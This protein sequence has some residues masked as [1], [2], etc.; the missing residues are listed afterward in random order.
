M[1]RSLSINY[2][3]TH[4]FHVVTPPWQ[5]TWRSCVTRNDL[6]ALLCMSESE[7][8]SSSIKL[9]VNKPSKTLPKQVAFQT[10]FYLQTTFFHVD[11]DSKSISIILKSYLVE[12]GL[13]LLYIKYIWSICI[14]YKT[15]TVFWIII[16]SFRSFFLIFQLDPKGR[17]FSYTKPEVILGNVAYGILWLLRKSIQRATNFELRNIIESPISPLA[18]VIW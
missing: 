18:K 15:D 13:F 1:V 8:G 9:Q 11:R 4:N 16:C 12:N 17:P 2:N 3:M 7:T 5:I 10:H 14:R 6:K